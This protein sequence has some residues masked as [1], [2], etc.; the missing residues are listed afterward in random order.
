MNKIQCKKIIKSKGP[1]P[2]IYLM[3]F[4]LILVTDIIK[5]DVQRTDLSTMHWVGC[6]MELA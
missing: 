5:F 4:I 3:I 1:L 6:L 2:K